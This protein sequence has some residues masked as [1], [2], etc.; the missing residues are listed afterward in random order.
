V[1]TTTITQAEMSYGVAKLEPG[2]RKAELE[3]YFHTLFHVRFKDRLLTFDG[4]AA[5]VY[6]D[7]LMRRRRAGLGYKHQDML[8]AAIE[9]SRGMSVATRDVGDFGTT[10]VEIIDPWQA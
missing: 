3:G 7:V 10:G 2:K 8:I 5:S 4:A 9:L 1:Y 6:G